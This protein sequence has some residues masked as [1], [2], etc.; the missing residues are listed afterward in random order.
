MGHHA[1]NDDGVSRQTLADSIVFGLTDDIV[2][3]RLEPGTA[4]DEASLG[5]RFGASRTPVREALRQLAAGGL[6]EL[7][8][9]RAPLVARIETRRLA[10]MFEVM[11]EL[12]ALCAARASV[13]MTP[14]QRAA[15]KRQH[16]EMGAAMR[17]ADVNAY[18]SGNVVLHSLIYDGAA[19]AY[20]GELARA[21]RERLAPY[22]AAQLD[23]P[24]RL[25][26]SYAEHEAIV[27]AILRGESMRAA[28]LMRAHLAATRDMVTALAFP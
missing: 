10:E 13:A 23:A 8:P 16:E 14:A 2:A 9:H 20:L 24:L 1:I 19:N 22:R 17:S 18:R 3:K 27:T 28:E 4:L 6:V 21:T 5:R 12:E 25:A 26:K 7:R 15:L 11:A